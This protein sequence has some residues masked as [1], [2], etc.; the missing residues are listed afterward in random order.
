MNEFANFVN[1]ALNIG[2]PGAGAVGQFPG[3]GAVGTFPQPVGQPAPQPMQQPQGQS[4]AQPIGGAA[5]GFNPA[6]FAQNTGF[7]SNLEEKIQDCTTLKLVGYIAAADDTLTRAIDPE[8]AAAFLAKKYEEFLA[9]AKYTKTGE[10]NKRAVSIQAF[11]MSRGVRVQ[12]GNKTLSLKKNSQSPTL[13]LSIDENKYKE[14]KNE[15]M[16]KASFKSLKPEYVVIKNEDITNGS[17]KNQSVLGKELTTRNAISS[18]NGEYIVILTQR[19]LEFMYASRIY[20]IPVEVNGKVLGMASPMSVKGKTSTYKLIFS[21]NESVVVKNIGELA[22]GNV[23]VPFAALKKTAGEVPTDLKDVL[24]KDKY[25]EL[26]GADARKLGTKAAR[27]KENGKFPK[28][29]YYPH[30][31]KWTNIHIDQEMYSKIITAPTGKSVMTLQDVLKD[32]KANSAR[33]A[34]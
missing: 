10:P 21:N 34:V 9:D 20:A 17:N 2:Q 30:S 8:K 3:A 23:R 33:F 22:E 18:K 29:E 24:N 27:V 6:V 7:K 25:K 4:V 12:D 11:K 13:I 14:L 15:G 26:V 28:I 31:A 1:P 32:F 16:Y 19:F 5:G